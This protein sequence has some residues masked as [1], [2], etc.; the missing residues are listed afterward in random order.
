MVPVQGLILA[1]LRGQHGADE[2]RV[3]GGQVQALVRARYTAIAAV[4]S[5]AT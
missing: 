4:I 5:L 1:G 2:R 3:R